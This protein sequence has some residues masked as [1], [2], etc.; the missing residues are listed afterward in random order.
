MTNYAKRTDANHSELLSEIMY[1]SIKITLPWPPSLNSYYRHPSSGKLAGRHLISEKGRKYRDDVGFAVIDQLRMMPR[2]KDR[3]QVTLICNPPDLRK[4]DIDNLPKS[5]FDALAHAQV[6]INDNQIDDF[7]VIRGEP[8][9][10]GQVL[11]TVSKI[12]R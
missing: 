9:K 2:L 5:I 3:L 11:V 1:N 4:R 8:L 10:G 7:R 12:E 6:Y